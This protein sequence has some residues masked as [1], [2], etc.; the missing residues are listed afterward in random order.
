MR[1]CSEPGCPNL[2]NKPGKCPTHRSRSERQRGTPAQ[3]GYGTD[4]AQERARW[5]PE[6]RAGRVRC[7]KCRR[8]LRPTEPWDLGHTT[9]R[10]G[11][12]GPECI[13]CNRGEGGRM[14]SR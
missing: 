10:T 1:I 6:V 8:L 11:W 12:T 3:R 5:E 4:H 9:D 2:L 14:A 7:A 13:T